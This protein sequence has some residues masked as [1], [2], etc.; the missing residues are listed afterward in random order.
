MVLA[1]RR[2]V[3]AS[4]LL[5]VAAGALPAAGTTPRA[6]RDTG[7]TVQRL[8]QARAA[9]ADGS[10]ADGI[11]AA[12]I[13]GG[14]PLSPA[15]AVPQAQDLQG[16]VT[17]LQEATRIAGQRATRSLAIPRTAFARRAAALKPG[18]ARGTAKLASAVDRQ[19]L[20]HA[21]R[22]L[23]AVVDAAAATLKHTAPELV[24]DAGRRVAGCD[25][26]DQPP[27]LCIGG[28]GANAYSGEYALQI[29][30]G[31][32]DTYTNAGAA[33]SLGNSLP[34]AVTIDIGGNDAYAADLAATGTSVGLG[35]A[36]IGGI[37]LL[38]DVAGNDR[39]SVTSGV[40]ARPV[41][42]IGYAIGGVG[43]LADATG[44]DSYRATYAPRSGETSRA[45]SAI[46]ISGLAG[47]GIVIDGAGDDRYTAEATP[48]A[49]DLGDGVSFVPN[50]MVFGIGQGV[51]GI[52]L[53]ADGAGT[54]QMEAIAAPQTSD[55][56][57]DVPALATVKGLGDGEVG[58]VGVVLGGAGDTTYMAR[59]AT[60]GAPA[61]SASVTALGVGGLAGYGA[62][63]DVAGNDSFL[64]TAATSSSRS[65]R[66]ADACESCRDVDAEAFTG[67]AVVS[68]MGFASL[69]ATGV[70]R[71]S[72]G[73][74]RYISTATST[75]ELAA[76]D[77][78]TAP[79]G[80][81]H[82]R[83]FAGKA[84][85]KAQGVAAVDPGADLD[86]AVLQL[87]EQ[88]LLE[89]GSIGLLMDSLGDDRY[90]SHASAQA[91]SSATAAAAPIMES[92]VTGPAR[93]RAQGMGGG[94]GHGQL[95]DLAGTDVYRSTNTTTATAPGGSADP[96]STISEVQGSGPDAGEDSSLPSTGFL[97]DLDGG[98]ADIFSALPADPVCEGGRGQATWR[99]CGSQAAGGING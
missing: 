3:A 77:D 55:Y 18:D 74:D 84:T 17:A 52:G 65:V 48:R 78:R 93:S 30:L 75:A 60:Q 42:G 9:L 61:G 85:S 29:D 88:L 90:E 12:S 24:H 54:D 81:L 43:V 45:V 2:A 51:A 34:A 14:A 76:R 23:A 21:A 63:D 20:L 62:I 31:G 22:D 98:A 5:I 80:G 71:D 96:G 16:T 92:A 56:T 37:G 47:A 82:A 10:L 49:I 83:A 86:A 97:I 40:A 7:V 44:N 33:D 91:V 73:S 64:A 59:A 26:A 19:A 79:N 36:A 4:A 38:V 35:S 66:V 50:A 72:S 27:A 95:R 57:T 8:D 87:R 1:V 6:A 25:L 89:D 70:V 13:L 41:N 39:Y 53:V 15:R 99:D 46:G 58:G 68:A 32:D 67:S 69:G 28:P 11:E 94:G